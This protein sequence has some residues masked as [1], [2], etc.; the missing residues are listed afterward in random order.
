M[1]ISVRAWLISVLSLLSILSVLSLRDSS[2]QPGGPSTTA[3]TSS[4]A[5]ASTDTDPF[6]SG[7][8]SPADVSGGAV[9]PELLQLV[10][11][12]STD[13]GVPSWVGSCTDSGRTVGACVSAAMASLSIKDAVD[14]D[15]TIIS[16]L[17]S[18]GGS[19]HGP[20][21]E[22]GQRAYRELKDPFDAVLAGSDV[23]EDGFYHGVFEAWGGD[24]GS[25]GLKREPDLCKRITAALSK[26]ICAHGFG[27]ALWFAT[28]D[29]KGSLAACRELPQDDLQGCV[30]GVTMSFVQDGAVAFS[31]TEEVLRFCTEYPDDV[32][33]GCITEISGFLLQVLGTPEKVA[34]ACPSMKPI[35]GVRRCLEGAGMQLPFAVNLRFEEVQR[36]CGASLYPE[37]C[38]YGAVKQLRFRPSSDA[39]KLAD[40]LCAY[41]PA[42]CTNEEP[43]LADGPE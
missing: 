32:R 1:R 39:A 22:L 8:T 4:S 35:K 33:D 42:S 9:R 13:S 11:M 36:V 20:T 18:L 2:Y 26:S 3:D 27:H 24:V 17:P 28:H 10:G 34:L 21:H 12:P 30:S 38:F 6:P 16:V 43:G 19:C 31:S 7:S 14:L 25:E 40:R 29:V 15:A 23:C 5:S 41:S 37:S